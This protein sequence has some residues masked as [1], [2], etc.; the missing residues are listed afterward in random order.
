MEHRKQP[1]FK[2]AVLPLKHV[3]TTVAVKKFLLFSFYHTDSFDNAHTRYGC[4][5]KTLIQLRYSGM[6][7]QMSSF[8]NQWQ[9]N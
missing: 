8:I 7:S 9:K 3:P 2:I 1:V 4:I 6:L 5:R